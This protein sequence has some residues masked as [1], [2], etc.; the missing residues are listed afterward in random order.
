MKQQHS[1]D[2]KTIEIDWKGRAKTKQ[3][4]S[5]RRRQ[6]E[7]SENNCEMKKIDERLR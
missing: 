3:S 2:E 7:E 5:R 4:I 6:K 1:T